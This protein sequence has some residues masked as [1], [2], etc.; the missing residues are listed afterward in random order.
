LCAVIVEGMAVAAL[1]GPVGEP[2]G[3]DVVPRPNGIY[4][5]YALAADPRVNVEVQLKEMTR[6]EFDTLANT[7]QMDAA[8]DGLAEAAFQRSTGSMG[9]PGETV[10]AFGGGRGVTI[11]ITGEGDSVA[12][13]DAADVMAEAALAS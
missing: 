5:H 9:S 2:L 12:Q 13:L 1:G 3:G 6:A 11:V 10:I 8:I 4:C 7:M